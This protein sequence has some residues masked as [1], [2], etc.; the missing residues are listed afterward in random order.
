MQL[1]RKL[2]LD[3]LKTNGAT[4]VDELAAVLGLT[5][6]TVR[7]HLDILRSEELVSKP[8][9]KHRASPGRPQ[10]AYALASKASAHF[11]KHYD[12]LAAKVLAEL[13]TVATPEQ[14]NVIFMGV[15][16]R[17]LTDAP[18]PLPGEPLPARLERA[19]AFLNERGFVSSFE[20]APGGF[21]LRA[22]NCPYEALAGEHAELCGIDKALIGH[23]LGVIPE[24]A[25]RLADGSDECAFLIREAAAQ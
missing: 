14:V 15:Q 25:A 19:V 1:T 23:L 24:C 11:P 9:V 18:S 16:N 13:K 12:D 2:I 6:V 22:R 10:Y 7:H 17:M 20:R 21:R 4:T 8:V 5:T 3:Y